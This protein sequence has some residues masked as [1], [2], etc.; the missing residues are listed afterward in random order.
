[1]APIPVILFL[2]GPKIRAKSRIASALQELE[3]EVTTVERKFEEVDEEVR[4]ITRATIRGVE[5]AGRRVSVD[6]QTEL[7]RLSH[8]AHQHHGVD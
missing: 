7:R 1:M 5:D 3:N 4:Q 8:Y 6:V 2:Y